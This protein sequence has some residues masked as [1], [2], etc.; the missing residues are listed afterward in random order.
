MLAKICSGGLADAAR[1]LKGAP[2]LAEF[3]YD[4][5]VRFRTIGWAEVR[6]TGGMWGRR[7]MRRFFVVR[8]PCPALHT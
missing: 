8:S 2:F 5:Q 7:R 6:F 1:Q 4:G 3:K